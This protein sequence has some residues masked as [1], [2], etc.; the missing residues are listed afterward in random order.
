MEPLDFE[1]LLD[2][3]EE[4][5]Q[6]LERYLTDFPLSSEA[7][8]QIINTCRQMRADLEAAWLEKVTDDQRRAM[9]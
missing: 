7:I 2:L 9:G 1:V 8:P 6:E 3:V 4:L 5:E